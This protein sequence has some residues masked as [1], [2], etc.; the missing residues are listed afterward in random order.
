MPEQESESAA[1]ALESRRFWETG[2]LSHPTAPWPCPR[3]TWPSHKASLQEVKGQVGWEAVVRSC[4]GRPL[5]PS[6][7]SPC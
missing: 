7:F 4:V 2:N 5:G 6:A 1:G 3:V